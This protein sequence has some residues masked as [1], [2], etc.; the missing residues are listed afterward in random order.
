[1]L[2][3]FALSMEK[4]QAQ[5]GVYE[6][7]R[8]FASKASEHAARIAGVLTV[9][10]D[11]EALAVSAEEMASGVLLATYYADEAMRLQNAAVIPP[12]I[13]DAELMKLWL[14]TSW[15]EEF[16]TAGLAAQRGPNRLRTAEKC[17]KVF[18]LLESHGWLARADG[19]E[20]DGKQR[21]EAWRVVRS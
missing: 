9:F 1:V 17:K 13:A 15:G 21:R 11:P 7:A 14:L 20:V 16:V 3:D 19:A 8:A 4:A 6:D 18:A 10:A 2:V 12:H 5:G